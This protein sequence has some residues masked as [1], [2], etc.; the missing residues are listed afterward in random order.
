MMMTHNPIKWWWT[1]VS[2]MWN[3]RK[4]NA[5]YKGTSLKWK[6]NGNKSEECMLHAIIIATYTP[7]DV[8]QENQ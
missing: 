7:S 8:G 3:C 2:E 6:E 5:V 4:N 1:V